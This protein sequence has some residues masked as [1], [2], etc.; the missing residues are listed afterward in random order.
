MAENVKNKDADRAPATP[1]TNLEEGLEGTFPAS[2]PVS[3]TRPPEAE[4][5]KASEK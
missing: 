4:R 1:E 5:P 3:A 2:D